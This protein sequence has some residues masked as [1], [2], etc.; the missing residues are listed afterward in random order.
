[1]TAN[2]TSKA[3]R[4][5]TAKRGEFVNAHKDHRL[6]GEVIC[7]NAGKSSHS[8]ANVVA[9]LK[10]ADLNEKVARELLP[11]YAFTRAMKHLKEERVIDPLKETGDVI[12]FLFTKRVMDAG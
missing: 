11:R 8:H 6:L 7:W 5:A 2:K 3:R 9:A 4:S 1:M 10:D 12:T